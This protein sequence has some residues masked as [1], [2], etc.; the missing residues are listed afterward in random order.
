LRSAEAVRSPTQHLAARQPSPIY[1]AAIFCWTMTAVSAAMVAVV[2]WPLGTPHWFALVKAILL[3]CAVIA[4][5][6]LFTVRHVERG[7][8]YS[9]LLVSTV[10]VI[11]LPCLAWLGVALADIVIYPL[12]LG[13]L[14]AGILQTASAARAVAAGRWMFAVACGGLAGC[15]YFL[16]INSRGFGSVL[17]TELALTGIHQMDTIFHSAIANM[18][19][20]YEALST[21]LDGFVP[22]QYHVLS[23]VWLGCIGLWLGVSTLEAY[24]IGGQVIGIPM[25]LFALSLA[26]HLFRRAGAVPVNGALMTLG[27]LLL[28][29]L[30]DLWGWTSY[31]I[32]ESYF[33]A[34]ILFLMVLPLLV[35]IVDSKERHRLGPQLATLGVVGLLILLSKISVGAVLTAAVG[36]LVWRRMGMTPLGLL[37]LAVPLLLLVIL[38]VAVIS[39]GTRYLL[40]AIEPFGFIREHPAG[41]L[42][43]MAANLLL[44]CAAYLVWRRGTPLDRRCAEL[45]AVIAIA[46]VGPT[47]FV[48]VPGGSD[49]Y[50]INVGTWTAIVFVCAYG[51]AHFERMFPDPLAPAVVVAAILLVALLTDEKRHSAYRLGAMFAQLQARI[52]L[53]TGENAGPETTTGRR[54]VELLT[55]GHQARYMLA[56]DVKRT[57]G[58]QARETLQAM[59]IAQAPRGAVFVP[60][61]N[62]AFWANAV[63][64]RADPVFVPAILGAPMLKGFNP[65][66]RNCVRGPYYGFLDYVDANSEALSDQQ[67]CARAAS[68]KIDVVFILT[69]PTLGRKIRCG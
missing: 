52:R 60:P 12:F 65:V 35:E 37:K 15:G 13:L 3:P 2:R 46:S 57:P 7:G 31:L 64:C 44:L 4:C 40:E 10:A 22:I 8:A 6:T 48:N 63:E 32:S 39:P 28:L 62:A 69:A 56:N 41:A 20:K 51:G 55:P 11:F 33:L 67:L 21:G 25:L 16:I 58:A 18:L 14:V 38:A 24:S 30:V 50:F 43:N 42:P 19:V 23:H 47:L 53:L 27:S 61:D 34:M 68:W 1:F 54:L 17:T 36:F 9:L 66:A 26:I 45:A 5:A 29:F 59:G 49:Y